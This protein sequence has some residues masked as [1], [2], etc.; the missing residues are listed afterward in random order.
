MRRRGLEYVERDID[1]AGAF[2]ECRAR[3]RGYLNVSN[4]PSLGRF[5]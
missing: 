1:D 3:L 5:E 2:V 4:E